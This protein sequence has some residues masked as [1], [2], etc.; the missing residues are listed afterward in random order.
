MFTKN[1]YNGADIIK[2]DDSDEARELKLQYA[3]AG[4]A[5]KVRDFQSIEDAEDTLFKDFFK[6]EG[7]IYNLKRRYETFIG[8]LMENLPENAQY[9]YIRSSYE[10]VEYKLNERSARIRSVSADDDGEFS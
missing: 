8:K 6:A 7:V 10:H 4:Y 3:N 5:V 9:K 1:I 2:V